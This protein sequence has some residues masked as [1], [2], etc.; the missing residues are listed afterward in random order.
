MAPLEHGVRRSGREAP[1][2]ISVV[3]FNDIPDG[4]SFTP[5][6]GRVHSTA[7]GAHLSDW[8]KR[9]ARPPAPDGTE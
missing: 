8:K 9:Q 3:G 4:T 2:D 6:G 7:C 5:A 1:R